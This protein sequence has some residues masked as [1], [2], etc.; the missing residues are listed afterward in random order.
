MNALENSFIIGNDKND[1]D[2]E[3]EDPESHRFVMV[4]RTAYI[5]LEVQKSEFHAP[6]QNKL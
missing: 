1:N 2:D 5:I 6:Q 3:D 4:A